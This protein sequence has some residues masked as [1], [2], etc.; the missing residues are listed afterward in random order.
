MQSP[1]RVTDD[2]HIL[3]SFVPIPGFGVLMANA[4]VIKAQEPV[5]VDTGLHADEG[6][7]L[8]ALKSVIDPAELRWLWL[9]HPDQDHVGSLRALL[10]VAPQIRLVTTFLGV[11]ILGLFEQVPLDRVHL[12]NPG[13]ELDVGDRKLHAIKPPTFDNPATT[14][15]YDSKS[16]ALFSSDCFGAL[17]SEPAESANAIDSATLKQQMMLWTGVDSPWLHDIDQSKL[18]SA[19]QRI[20]GLDAEYVLSSHL[21]PAHGLMNDCLANLAA[22]PDAAPFVGPD[23]EALSAMLASM[24]GAAAHS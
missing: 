22:V 10:G 23:Q 4:F 11:G 15:F 7:F 19:L 12:V 5:L 3:P 16:R 1:A 8:E 21:P 9:T 20:R 6:A 18:G 13:Q 24:T 14:G 2:I 17:L